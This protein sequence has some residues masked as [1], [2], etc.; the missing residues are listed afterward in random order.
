VGRNLGILG[1]APEQRGKGDATIFGIDNL[2]R[3]CKY[4]TRS[5]TAL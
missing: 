3:L 2:Q 1:L 5:F 4:P